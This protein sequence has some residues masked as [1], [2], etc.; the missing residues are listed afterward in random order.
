MIQSD[1]LQYGPTARFIDHCRAAIMRKETLLPSTKVTGWV[2]FVQPDIIDY[3]LKYMFPKVR[4]SD[5][6]YVAL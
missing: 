2:R 4:V 3:R 5:S 6:L 1:A